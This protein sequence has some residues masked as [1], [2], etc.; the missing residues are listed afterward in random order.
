MFL[1]GLVVLAGLVA[2]WI[3]GWELTLLGLRQAG[4]LL[5]RVWL[6]LLLG[7]V[8][9]G[10]IQVLIPTSLVVQWLGPASGLKGILI[11]TGLSLTLGAGPYVVFPVIASIRKAGAGAG[12]TITLIAGWA[13]LSVN[14]LIVWQFP[15][16]GVEIPLSRYVACLVITPLAG[17]AG[18]ALFRLMNRSSTA[19]LADR[20]SGPL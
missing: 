20:D 15:F 12:A 13:M 10:L 11:A 18:G 5:Q 4:G 9:G 16:L 19:R 17:L 1:G 2:F 8:L 7:L 6:P 3:G 14:S